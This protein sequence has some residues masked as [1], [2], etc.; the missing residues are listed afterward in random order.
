[1]LK[2]LLGSLVSAPGNVAVHRAA[3]R[4]R[5]GLDGVGQVAKA[6]AGAAARATGPEE[7]LIA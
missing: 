5:C 7:A 4:A 6:W 2:T 1:M 3:H